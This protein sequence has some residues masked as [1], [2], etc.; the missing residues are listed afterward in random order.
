MKSGELKQ[1]DYGSDEENRKHYNGSSRPPAYD[2]SQIRESI[3]LYVGQ[4]DPVINDVEI[5]AIVD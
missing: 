3:V 5:N 1:Y 2:L 4:H